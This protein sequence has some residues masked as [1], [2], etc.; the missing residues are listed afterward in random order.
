MNALED[1]NLTVHTYDE[2]IALE[3][4]SKIKQTYFPALKQLY[5]FIK[6]EINK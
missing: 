2:S 4:I 3:L 5:N 6:K 1:R